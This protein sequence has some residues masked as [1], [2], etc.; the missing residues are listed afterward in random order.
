MA[1]AGPASGE[2][3]MKIEVPK[4]LEAGVEAFIRETAA[5]LGEDPKS[6]SLQRVALHALLTRG[7]RRSGLDPENEPK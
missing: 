7:L 5:R 2:G 6:K 3:V 4:S 1:Q